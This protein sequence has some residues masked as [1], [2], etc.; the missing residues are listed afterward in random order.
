MSGISINEDCTHFYYSRSADEMTEEGVDGFIETY[1]G[2]QVRE[3][4]FNVNARYTS[5]LPGTEWRNV[6]LAGRI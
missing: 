4:K 3:I 5:C 2:T 6:F 1:A